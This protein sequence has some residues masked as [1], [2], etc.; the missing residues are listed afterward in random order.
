MNRQID[1]FMLQGA[2]GSGGAWRGRVGRGLV[3]WGRVWLGTARR[4]L[5]RQ[6]MERSGKARLGI[7]Q[8]DMA[9]RGLRCLSVCV[10]W[11]KTW[12]TK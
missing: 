2:V 6:S 8:C 7:V 4:G 9:W 3:R 10:E 11:V 1:F 5:V 12:K